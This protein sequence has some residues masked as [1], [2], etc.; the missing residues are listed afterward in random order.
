MSKNN[1]NTPVAESTA[2]V[3]AELPV[4]PTDKA[5]ADKAIADK[6]LADKALADKVIADKALADKAIADKALAD[7]AIADKALADKEIADKVHD[8]TIIPLGKFIAE[9]GNEY[10]FN[11]SSFTFQGKT[12]TKE[13][14][15]SDHTDVLEHLASIKS[16]IL[17]KV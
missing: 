6:A 16:F 8:A 12:Y 5:L 2:G 9:N 15:L 11:V 14:A 7:K 1:T 17:K 13:E 3:N 4:V 10:E